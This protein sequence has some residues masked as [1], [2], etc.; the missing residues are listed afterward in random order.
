MRHRLHHGR[1]SRATGPRKALMRQLAA[2]VILEGEVETT[3]AKAK[4]VAAVVDGLAS[5]AHKGAARDSIRAVLRQLPSGRMGENASRRLFERVEGAEASTGFVQV[6]RT[7]RRRGD[8]AEMSL[9][10]FT[11]LEVPEPEPEEEDEEE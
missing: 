10:R 5:R 6:L 3:H 9:V 1:L 8:G 7:R 4:A 11:D 2:Q